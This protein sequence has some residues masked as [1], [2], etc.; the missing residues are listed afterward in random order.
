VA[1]AH[2]LSTTDEHIKSVLG[3]KYG[4]FNIQPVLA[5]LKAEGCNLID[6]GNDLKLEALHKQ[7]AQ[8]GLP[9]LNLFGQSLLG[10]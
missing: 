2:L 6:G 7:R 5:R 10:Q 1:M 8:D 9:P 4:T 3:P